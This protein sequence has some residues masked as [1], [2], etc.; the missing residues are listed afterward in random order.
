MKVFEIL[1][2]F[3]KVCLH[4]LHECQLFWLVKDAFEFLKCLYWWEQSQEW[5]P[6]GS[7]FKYRRL[8]FV[9]SLC[10]LKWHHCSS[11]KFLHWWSV[12]R[13]QSGQSLHLAKA[14]Q[15]CLG[16]PE[17]AILHRPSIVVGYR[18]RDAGAPAAFQP[19]GKQSV[20]Q[21]PIRPPGPT[22]P[23]RSMADLFKKPEPPSQPINVPSANT[24]SSVVTKLQDTTAPNSHTGWMLNV[25]IQNL[26]FEFGA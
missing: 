19:I 7:E 16:I 2:T 3:A 10:L 21:N 25:Y 13:T 15:K 11:S 18:S 20:G 22:T 6:D 1:A 24:S 23:G 8:K 4:Q 5:S 12:F 14:I 17:L 9:I 26:K